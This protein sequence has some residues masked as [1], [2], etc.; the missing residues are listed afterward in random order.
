MFWLALWGITCVTLY[1]AVFFL[2]LLMAFLAGA[3]VGWWR[4]RNTIADRITG[5][6]LAGLLFSVIGFAIQ[7]IPETTPSLV[8][9]ALVMGGFYAVI[10][11]VL[12]MVGG[13]IGALLAAALRRVRGGGGP[14]AELCKSE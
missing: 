5:G 13:L 7:I 11:M 14:A 4:N 9:E 3:L 1:P 8:L 2:H 6:M 12:G 10:G